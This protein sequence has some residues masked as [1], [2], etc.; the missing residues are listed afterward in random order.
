MVAA[1][2]PSPG[3]VST[4][5]WRGARTTST[6]AATSPANTASATAAACRE[7]RRWWVRSRHSIATGSTSVSA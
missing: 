1:T 7:R 3:G 4:S 6:A 2:L 5:G